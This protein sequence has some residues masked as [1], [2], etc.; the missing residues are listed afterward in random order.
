MANKKS[1][2]TVEEIAPPNVNDKKNKKEKKEKKKKSKFKAFLRLLVLII[3]G[4]VCYIYWKPINT[5][6]APYVVN[7]PG[8][9]KVFVINEKAGLYDGLTTDDLIKQIELLQDNI[10][11]SEEQIKQKDLEIVDLKGQIERLQVF[12]NEYNAF[13]KEKNDF[14][15]ALAQANPELFVEQYEKMEKE[16]ANDIYNNLIEGVEL[17]A[18]Q[19]AQAETIGHMDAAAAAAAIELLLGTDTELVK[20][21]FDNMNN[22]SQASIL[23]EMSAE[24][25][26]QA[27]R[28]TSP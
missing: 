1:G 9:N 18:A 10:L 11:S 20:N 24:S 6:V 7:V 8:L 22:A 2:V 13:V 27:I 14:N 17:S 21:I 26:A 4:V 28:L 25:A 15:F 5:F 12:E 23:D 3:L 16:I 19:Q